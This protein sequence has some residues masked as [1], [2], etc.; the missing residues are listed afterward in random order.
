LDWKPIETAPKDGT[1]ILVTPGDTQPITIGW[2]ETGA[3]WLSLEMESCSGWEG[4]YSWCSNVEI[5]PK[6]WMPLPRL[7]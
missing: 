4:G 6:L 1:K 7:P 5:E 3:R 2:Y